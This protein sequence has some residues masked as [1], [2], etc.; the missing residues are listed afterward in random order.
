VLVSDVT[1]KSPA[2][3]AGIKT[4]DVI[5]EFNGKQVRDSRH[6]KLHVAQ[7]A[8]GESVPVKILRDGKTRTLQVAVKEL[9]GT[10]VASNS[11]K[12]DSDDANDSLHGVAVGDLNGA[13]REQ[14]KI[15]ST[16]KGVLVMGVEPDSAAYDAGLR[17]GDVIQ[18]I[19]RK[20]VGSTDEAVRLTEKAGSKT[21]LL[22]VWSKGGSRYVVVDESKDR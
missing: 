7:T 13:A 19:N 8:P 5:L 15:P 11:K 20:P 14:F 21:T 9:P 2:E 10:E 6:L 3:K 17:E 22:R 4:G 1:T 16:V 12:S 18:E